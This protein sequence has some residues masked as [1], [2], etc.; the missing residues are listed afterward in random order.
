MVVLSVHGPSLFPLF[1]T[2]RN[3][4][5]PAKIK[6]GGGKTHR[7]PYLAHLLLL[8][9]VMTRV[10]APLA[11]LLL[12]IVVMTR[13]LA[14][15]APL[16]LLIVVMTC[17]LAPLAHLLLLIVVMTRFLAFSHPWLISCC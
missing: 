8:I 17:V 15:L 12:L 3:F 14:P 2:L 6:K 4:E 7:T 1:F 16:L 13:V 9:I 5:F 10:L 11:H